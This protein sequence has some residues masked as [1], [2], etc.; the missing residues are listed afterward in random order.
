MCYYLIVEDFQV[1]ERSGTEL[2]TLW[3]TGQML[4]WAAWSIRSKLSDE[5][6]SVSTGRGFD[7]KRWWMEQW[8]SKQF[9]GRKLL[10]SGLWMLGVHLKMCILK[11]LSLTP[12]RNKIITHRH[13]PD[14]AIRAATKI[15]IHIHTH[16]KK[17]KKKSKTTHTYT[18][19]LHEKWLK[20]LIYYQF[21]FLPISA[22]ID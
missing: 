20:W 17:K 14:Y 3:C 1:P 10:L 21:V 8:K 2:H 12:R 11:K 13:I 4:E 22:H 16:S 15:N 6:S 9:C 18:R 19:K 5:K 7:D